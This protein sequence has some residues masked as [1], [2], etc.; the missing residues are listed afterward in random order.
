MFTAAAFVATSAGITAR[1]LKDMGVLGCMESRVILDA[2][3]I[4]DILA[5]LLLGVVTALQRDTGANVGGLLLILLQAVGF[6]AL[7]GLVGTHW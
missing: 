2:A 3:V 1:V 5:I 4:D 7:I 6:V